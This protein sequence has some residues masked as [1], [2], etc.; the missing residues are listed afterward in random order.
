MSPA[1]DLG[2]LDRFTVGTEGQVGTARL[3]AAVPQRPHRGHLEGREATGVGAGRV[4]RTSARRSRPAR[5]P[6]RPTSSSKSPPSRTGSSAPSGS[7][8]TTP[9]TASCWWPRSSWPRTR[10]ATWPASRSPAPRPPPSPS[11]PPPWSKPGVRRARCAAAPSTRR[12]TSAPGPT[13]TGRPPLEAPGRG[14]HRGRRPACRGARTTPSSPRAPWGRRR[15][16]RCTSPG[17]GSVICGTSPRRSTGARSPPTSCR[18]RS[19]G[20]S[21]PRPS[22][23][24][25]RPSGPGRCSCFIPADFS[26]HHFTL[27]EDEAPPRPAASHLR[28][29]R[30]GQQRRPQERALHPRRGRQGVGHRQRPVLPPRAQAAHRD[31]GVRRGAT[32]RRPCRRP[33]PRG[34]CPRPTPCAPC[35]RRARWPPSAGAPTRCSRRDGS[36]SPT[37][38]RTTTPGPWSDP[39]PGGAGWSGARR[40]K[41]EQPARP[42]RQPCPGRGGDLGHRQG[43]GGEPAPRARCALGPRRSERAG[44]ARAASGCGPPR[45]PRRRRSAS[46][47]TSSTTS[48]ASARRGRRSTTSSGPRQL[49]HHEL[50]GLHGAP[51]RGGQHELGDRHAGDRGAPAR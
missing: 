31:L 13:A 28:L 15:R 20:T 48:S 37:P 1:L 5:G 26:Q 40:A 46:A 7:A 17:A 14:R 32:A 47:R 18:R 21:S 33:G 30:R 22:N 25:T 4:P 16:P 42:G 3:P 23:V 8:T 49:R 24:T 38:T 44:R 9:S 45:A 12:D 11:A 35:S 41:S 36:R 19:D 50:G 43:G 27:V 2:D 34:R 6:P 39:G 10:R 51:R 29:R